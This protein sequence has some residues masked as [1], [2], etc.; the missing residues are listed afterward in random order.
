MDVRMRIIAWFQVAM[1]FALGMNKT[2]ATGDGLD[3]AQEGK[4]SE[5]ISFGFRSKEFFNSVYRF[6]S[7]IDIV[8]QVQVTYLHIEE[9]PVFVEPAMPEGSNYVRMSTVYA[10]FL[11]DSDF[12]PNFLVDFGLS[13]SYDKGP[14]DLPCKYLCL[15]VEVHVCLVTSFLFLQYI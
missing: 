11:D 1:N 7:I 3:N 9:V 14:N 12:V 6:Q 10:Q 13:G 4:A 8:V 15:S 5:F 2:K